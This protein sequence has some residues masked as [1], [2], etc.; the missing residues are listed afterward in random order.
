MEKRLS[1]KKNENSTLG[2]LATQSKKDN[3]KQI[4]SKAKNLYK[5]Y[6]L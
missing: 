1:N 4:Q 3:I 6:Q 2:K 5:E